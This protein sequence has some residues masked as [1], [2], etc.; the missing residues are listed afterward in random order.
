MHGGA[1]KEGLDF[2]GVI[3]NEQEYPGTHCDSRG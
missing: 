1:V 2:P 3:A